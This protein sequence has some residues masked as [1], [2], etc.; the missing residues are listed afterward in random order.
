M[1][2]ITEGDRAWERGSTKD[3][4][5]RIRKNAGF[6]A[7]PAFLRMRLRVHFL[8]PLALASLH[9]RQMGRGYGFDV[10]AFK[11]CNCWNSFRPRNAAQSGSVGSLS[12]CPLLV[13][14]LPAR[15]CASSS[16]ARLA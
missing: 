13:G 3:T 6:D 9:H 1:N 11:V 2:K 4:R 12:R 15:H 14:Y 8:L 16:I 10:S 7:S 5:S